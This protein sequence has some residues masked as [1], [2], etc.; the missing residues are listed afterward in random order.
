MFERFNL[1][2]VAEPGLREE[3]SLCGIIFQVFL[4]S[5]V[6]QDLHGYGNPPKGAREK[7]TKNISITRDKTSQCFLEEFFA[8]G[9]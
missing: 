8:L 1:S 5:S 4:F 6:L 2:K 3:L 7:R 9:Q